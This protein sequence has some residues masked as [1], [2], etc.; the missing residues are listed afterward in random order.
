MVAVG[1]TTLFLVNPS[2]TQYGIPRNPDERPNSS[3]EATKLFI[4]ETPPLQ[5]GDGLQLKISVRNLRNG[6]LIV[7]RGLANGATL[8]TGEPAG[9]GSWW[10][11]ASNV[12]DVRVVPPPE[13]VGPMD[14]TV[15]LRSA[16]AAVIEKESRRFNWIAQPASTIEAQ[17]SPD[18]NPTNTDK[19]IA[20]RAR[21][22]ELMK[23]HDFGAARLVLKRAVDAGD[24][25]SAIMLAET[26]DPTMLQQLGVHGL[27]P[28]ASLA[29]KWYTR[30]KELGSPEAA[31]RL[32]ALANIKM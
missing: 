26:Y 22:V 16:K 13:F 2:T 3:L 12:S 21:G 25:V 14:L 5:K 1:A 31:R 8:S 32:E 24:G 19:I 28:D 30:A 9:D 15:E 29:R 17:S 23:A 7:I 6:G 11:S 27:S 18:A 20:L 4:A 10:L